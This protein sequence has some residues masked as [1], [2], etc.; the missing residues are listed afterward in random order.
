MVCKSKIQMVKMAGYGAD[1]MP[2]Q[3]YTI[4]APTP[5]GNAMSYFVRKATTE[6]EKGRCYCVTVQENAED[7]SKKF[8][9]PCPFHVENR[10]AFG[11]ETTCKHC[12]AVRRDIEAEDARI[13]EFEREEQE[14]EMLRAQASE[15]AL[16]QWEKYRFDADP[17][18]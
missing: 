1:K 9:C 15:E 13:A 17:F 18:H 14:K 5:T 7:G 12:E 8:T 6:T 11:D 2:G 4:D 3:G 16:E 10:T